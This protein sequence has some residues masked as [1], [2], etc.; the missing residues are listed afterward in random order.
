MLSAV[1]FLPRC[2]TRLMNFWS[3]RLWYFGSGRIIRR[4]TR[5]LLGMGE[6]LLLRRLRAVL[7]AS[8]LPVVDARRVEGATDDVVANARQVLDPA[9]ADEHDRVLLQVVALARNVGGDFH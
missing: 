6:H 7:R 4:T 5:A 3:V 2:I 8:L 1:D 9:A